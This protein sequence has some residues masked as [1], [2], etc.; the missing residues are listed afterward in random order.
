VTIAPPERSAAV[1]PRLYATVV[2]C[3][4]AVCAGILAVLI[5]VVGPSMADPG[6]GLAVDPEPSPVVVALED[7][8]SWDFDD[9][10]VDDPPAELRSLPAPGPSRPV[11]VVS[12]APVG[13]SGGDLTVQLPDPR[14]ITSIA[15]SCPSGFSGRS[16][17]GQA[18]YVVPGVPGERCTLWFRGASPYKFVGVS[19]GQ[20]LA[21]DF[22]AGVARCE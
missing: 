21:C 15:V 20:R 4:A 22:D 12:V 3:G 17:Y 2:V 13:T 5:A 10:A 8:G 11:A 18:P 16:A 14:G 1:D 6:P 19:G 7:T 9:A